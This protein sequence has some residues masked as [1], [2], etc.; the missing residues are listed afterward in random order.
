MHNLIRALS[1][2]HWR[3][4]YSSFR[5]VHGSELHFQYSIGDA[6]LAIAE[7]LRR[8]LPFN[9]PLE[10]LTG[11]PYNP[12]AEYSEAF[13][14]PLEM[15]DVV[16]AVA[17]LRRVFQYSVGDASQ[18]SRAG[19][20]EIRILSFQ[21]SVGDAQLR[22]LFNRLEY[23]PLSILRWRCQVESLR[24]RPAQEVYAFNTPLEMRR[25]ARSRQHVGNTRFQYSVGDAFL[26]P[27]GPGPCAARPLSILRW[28]C[29]NCGINRPV[30]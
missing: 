24:R 19:C 25:V 26:L 17:A 14:T 18:S 20:A 2:L 12:K 6:L 21:Y 23:V 10:M 16:T 7:P 3:C 5:F 9:I 13:N 15:R 29:R 8:M 4:K 1:I 28:R 22:D 11:Q 27:A 30:L